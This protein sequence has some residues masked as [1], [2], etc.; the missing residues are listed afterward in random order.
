MVLLQAVIPSLYCPLIALQNIVVTYIGMFLGGDYVYSVQNFV[1]INMRYVPVCVCVCVVCVCLCV[2]VCVCVRTH[3]RTVYICVCP[4]I[5]FL[6]SPCPTPPVWS[7]VWCTQLPSTENS[8]LHQ[9]RSRTQCPLHS[10]AGAS[11]SAL[12]LGHAINSPSTIYQYVHI[13]VFIQYTHDHG[14]SFNCIHSVPHYAF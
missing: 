1:G 12:A 9:H 5:L 2:C 13:T 10:M 4:I 8:T 7:G 6:T 14:Q 3:L 11:D